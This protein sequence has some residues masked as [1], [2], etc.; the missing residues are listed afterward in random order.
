MSSP[1]F[2]IWL[3]LLSPFFTA[4]LPLFFHNWENETFWLKCGL[5]ADHFISLVRMRTKS[6]IADFYGSSGFQRQISLG[7]A[8]PT[9]A[10]CLIMWQPSTWCDKSRQVLKQI[11]WTWMKSQQRV[12]TASTPRAV[13]P[14]SKEATRFFLTKMRSR[15]FIGL[16]KE[17]WITGWFI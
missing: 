17:I 5:N 3:T 1:L 15:H 4:S 9:W 12:K 10:F 16:A 7:P 8:S 2:S 11:L 6:A 14:S 13:R